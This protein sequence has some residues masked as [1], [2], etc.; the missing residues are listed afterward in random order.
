MIPERCA[1][2]SRLFVGIDLSW[3][4]RVADAIVRKPTDDPVVKCPEM[5]PIL[6]GWLARLIG[7]PRPAYIAAFLD[8]RIKT[9]RAIET[10]HLPPKE[11]YKAG[12]SKCPPEYWAEVDGFIEV[13]RLH[14]IP[15]Y[16][17]EGWEA[18]DVAATVTRRA[19][20]AGLD[21]A[22]VTLDHDW[23][24]L[25]RDRDATA[26][27]VYCWSYGRREPT[28][29]GP[30]EVLADDGLGV[31]PARVPDMIAICGDGDNIAGARGIGATKAQ[32]A[33]DLWGDVPG[34]LAAP[35]GDIEAMTAASDVAKKARDK[36][37]RA[38][39]KLGSP[40]AVTALGRALAAF[41]DAAVDLGGEKIRR[42]IVAH[43]DS[44][45]LG[46]L[47]ATLDSHAPI[48]P[49]FSLAACAVGGLDVPA[50]AR[51]YRA[52]DFDV[53]ADDVVAS[54]LARPAA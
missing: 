23:R 19:L 49:P 4:C 3:W 28:T 16:R 52:L 48:D 7:K 33:L 37:K 43:R 41:S 8:S 21:V 1:D 31:A 18:D 24:A 47:L 17:A 27:E 45:E 30:A 50:L 38:A 42:A 20:A 13:L 26:G 5:R 6:F 36:A 29:I 46:L 34:I 53:M 22:L 51:L 44:V 32:I 25:V 2:P 9:W 12:R 54:D 15:C 39:D 35:A 10:E 11:Q 14:S 40:D